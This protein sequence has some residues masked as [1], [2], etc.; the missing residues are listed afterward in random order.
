MNRFKHILLAVSALAVLSCGE[1]EPDMPWGNDLNKPGGGGDTPAPD[2]VDA[3]VGEVLPVWSEGCLD[4]HCINSGNGECTF[5]I[6]PDGTTLLVDA[7]EMPVDAD[8]VPRRPNSSVAANKVYTSY[9]SHF[10]PGGKTYIDWCAPS[11]FH[12]DHI[13]TSRQSSGKHPEGQFALTGL[14]AVYDA[15]PFNNLLDLGYS[16]YGNDTTIPVL[17]G[18]YA[19]SGEWK[20]FVDWAVANKGM[21]AGR[22]EAGKEQITLANDKAKYSN[23]KIFNFIANGKAWYKK[24]GAARLIDETGGDRETYKGNASSAGF[25]IKY[26][27]FDYMAAGDLEKK[28][29]N[30][31]AYY[32]RDFVLGGLDVFKANH[33][34]NVNSWGS[35]MRAQ[36]TP[37]VILAHITTKKQPD[38]NIIKGIKTGNDGNNTYVRD[39]ENNIFFTNLD[40]SQRSNENAARLTAYS[41]HIVVRVAPE[42]GSYMVYMLDDSNMNYKVKSIHG[43]YNCK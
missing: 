35:Q 27:K 20:K 15:F 31:L 13:G 5:F 24:D 38:W 10:I 1:K 11:H 26:G 9:I 37:R 8:A 16:T 25:H 36:L 7:G 21:K 34:F 14:S 41:G 39:T 40:E 28:P 22:F 23:F 3:K 6:L 18:E 43:P 4:I 29:Q 42:G 30:A 33:H 17:D 12:I 19:T 2:L 32:Y